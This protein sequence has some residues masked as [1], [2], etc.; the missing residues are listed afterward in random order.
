MNQTEILK[1]LAPAWPR[2][3]GELKAHVSPALK[4]RPRTYG[5]RLV[6]GALRLY[7]WKGLPVRACLGQ[8]Y[9]MGAVLHRRWRVWRE[10]GVLRAMVAAYAGSLPKAHIEAWRV[11]LEQ[12]DLQV[13][14]HGTR[15][16]A[17]GW[18][19]VNRFW[20]EAVAAPL[21]IAAGQTGRQ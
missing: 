18:L 14:G 7:V 10:S 12:Y 15:N 17:M 1:Q 4:R 11:R 19:M 21:L 13:R 9:P 2:I 16:P 20:H 6:F 3:E 8:G 5:D